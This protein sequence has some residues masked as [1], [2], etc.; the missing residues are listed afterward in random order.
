MAAAMAGLVS[1]PANL[2]SVEAYTIRE[3]AALC[4]IGHRALRGRVD[5]GKLRTV[6]VDGVR[7]IPRAELERVGLRVLANGNAG[8]TAADGNPAADVSPAAVGELVRTIQ[9]QQEELARLR[10]LPRQ[11]D[12]ERQARE[13]VE[14]ELH[15]AR[16][17]C[18]EAV[19]AREVAEEARLWRERLAAAGW[20]ERRRMLREVRRASQAA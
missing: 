13:R 19:R 5:T 12:A 15:R 7:R 1:Q 9:K 8:R 16:A 14:Q 20:R 3:A 2:E 6:K 18:T 10:Q 17:E 4:G 11:V